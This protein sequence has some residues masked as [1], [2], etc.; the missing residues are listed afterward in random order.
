MPKILGIDI[1]TDR[2]KAENKTMLATRKKYFSERAKYIKALHDIKDKYKWSN[3]DL[4]AAGL[5]DAAVLDP[6]LEYIHSGVT[7]YGVGFTPIPIEGEIP[8]PSVTA[9]PGDGRQASELVND[10]M[11]RSL[12]I[13]SPIAQAFSEMVVEQGMTPDNARGRVDS[14]RAGQGIFRRPQ[15]I[16]L[17]G[18]GDQKTPPPILLGDDQK[19]PPPATPPVSVI[20]PATVPPAPTPVLNRTREPFNPPPRIM[21]DEESKHET[22]KH[23]DTDRFRDQQLRRRNLTREEATNLWSNTWK[24]FKPIPH[25]G[26]RSKVIGN[27]FVK[28]L[29]D[30][31][32]PDNYMNDENYKEK[33]RQAFFDSEHG[34]RYA[35]DAPPNVKKIIND[36]YRKPTPT[37]PKDEAKPSTPVL[38]TGANDDNVR[39][40]DAPFDDQLLPDKTLP[41]GGKM[42]DP[43]ITQFPDVINM[44]G[45]QNIPIAPPPPGNVITKKPMKPGDKKRTAIPESPP[46]PPPPNVITD[47]PEKPGDNKKTA[48]PDSPPIPPPGNVITEK[49][50]KPNTRKNVG[51]KEK[52]IPIPIPPERKIPEPPEPPDKR[53]KPKDDD[54]DMSTDVPDDHSNQNGY[55]YLR[56]F[57]D[58][59]S[60]IDLLQQTNKEQLEDIKEYDLYDIPISVNESFDNPVY[61]HTLAEKSL[62]FS[63]IAL[64]PGLYVGANVNREINNNDA[65]AGMIQTENTLVDANIVERVGDEPK[66][67]D[68]YNINQSKFFG[69][70]YRTDP[71][72]I[73]SSLKSIQTDPDLYNLLYYTKPNRSSISVFS[74]HTASNIWQTETSF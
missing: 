58:I 38:D 15:G 33:M 22:T 25:R 47:K 10:A 54:E 59:Y 52:P 16:Q 20:P 18:S 1:S 57:F 34:D 50:E 71:N 13:N 27:W 12:E 60:G 69:E 30:N 6:Y 45:R 24:L 42:G 39:A 48:I 63:G 43:T 74:T 29:T 72:E 17:L 26:E 9:M 14:I 53:P 46:I 66:W 70:A 3:D 68:P 44:P 49:P 37:P 28:Y 36:R 56:P 51:I 5:W 23:E 8:L 67:F 40:P 65:P 35:N 11:M 73:Q 32:P 19:V 64:D 4:K 31:P 21:P 41:G 61:M 7:Q 2:E 62:R 55:G